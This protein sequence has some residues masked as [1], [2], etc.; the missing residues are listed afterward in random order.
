V[1][2]DG[3]PYDPIH[4]QGEGHGG[5]EYVK[6]VDFKDYLSSTNMHVIKRLLVNYDTPRNI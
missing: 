2:R 1:L 4:G 3:M 6:M 5:L